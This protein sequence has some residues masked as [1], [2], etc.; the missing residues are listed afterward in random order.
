MSTINPQDKRAAEARSAQGSAGPL[1]RSVLFGIVIVAMG[2][3]FARALISILDV[4]RLMMVNSVFAEDGDDQ[5]MAWLLII[6]ILGS[7]AFTSWY[8]RAVSAY[9]GGR[10][11]AVRPLTLQLLGFAG[12]AGV[13]LLPGVNWWRAPTA[14]GTA[15]DPVFG[16]DETWGPLEWVFY[17]LPVILAAGSAVLFLLSIVGRIWRLRHEDRRDR[18]LGRILRDGRTVSGTVTE[19]A[20]TGL[21]VNDVPML[22]LV[23]GYTDHLGTA[24]WVTK[25][26]LVPVTAFPAVG[27]AVQVHYLDA[28]IANEKQIL[29]LTA[30]AVTARAAQQQGVRL[31]GVESTPPL[32][33][34]SPGVLL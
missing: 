32:R 13:A 1:L 7:I 2:A 21:I 4:F 8:T 27:D 17:A 19:L 18:M 10:I 6:G 34:G 5:P 20:R 16:N 9:T 23:V 31:E 14:V 3:V 11:P 12:A 30:A 22:R 29:V 33:H 28:D 26:A 25:Q 15:V 24:R